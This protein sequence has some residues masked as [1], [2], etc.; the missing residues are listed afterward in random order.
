MIK[1]EKMFAF[2]HLILILIAYSQIYPQ[3]LWI[4][5]RLFL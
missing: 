1:G 2:G 4:E 3:K 5:S